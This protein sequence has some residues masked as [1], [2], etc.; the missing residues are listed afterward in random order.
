VDD[1]PPPPRYRNRELSWLEFNE[2]VLALAE[3]ERVPLLERAKF[4]AIF[5]SNLDEFFQVRVAGLRQ[6]RQRAR[7]LGKGGT[8][9]VPRLEEAPLVCD[10]E[11]AQACLEVNDEL[12]E[13][14][15]GDESLPGLA[16]LLRRFAQ[17][18]DREQQDQEGR[19]HEDRE[20]TAR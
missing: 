18:G 17:V 20:Q 5:A 3:D 11:P 19:G 7:L 14:V 16:P 12:F 2:R 1:A 9:L 8:S 4:L 6:A 15:R 10:D 13:L